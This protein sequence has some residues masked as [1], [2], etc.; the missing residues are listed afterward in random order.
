MLRIVV[1]LVVLV[2]CVVL[3]QPVVLVGHTERVYA[4][5]ESAYGKQLATCSFDKTIKLWDAGRA[6]LLRT[7]GEAGGH[8]GVITA[9]GYAPKLALLASAA[10]DNTVKLWDVQAIKPAEQAVRNLVHPQIVNGI[11]FHPSGNTLATAGQDGVVRL[12]DISKKDTPAPK[13]FNAHVPAQ[14]ATPQ[15]IYA[16]LY[17]PDGKQLITASNDRSIRVWDAENFK[18][19][20][21]LRAGSDTPPLNAGY[22]KLCG[23]VLPSPAAGLL[24]QPASQGHTDQVY[25]LAITPDGKTLASGG[26]DRTVKFWNI[27]TGEHLR[28]LRDEKYKPAVS[29][30]ATPSHPGYVQAVKFSPDGKL[31]HSVGTA[32]KNQGHIATWNVA[33]GALVQAADMPCGAIYCL[34]VLQDGRRLIGCGPK[35]RGASD[36][37]AILLP[38]K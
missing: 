25:A 7:I 20:R 4:V 32:P 27:A 28:T 3:G 21:E 11:A 24:N 5:A 1:L 34:A 33:D 36:C 12:Y 16:L 37:E 6:K 22:L 2:P 35:A 19:L 10:A 13:Q 31:L 14:P 26:A 23:A 17:T 18:L 30:F 9:L 38:A 8:T 29:A 15:A